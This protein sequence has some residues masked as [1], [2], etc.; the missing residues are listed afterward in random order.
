VRRTGAEGL[1]EK[2]H[3][4]VTVTYL[5]DNRQVSGVLHVTCMQSTPHASS[6]SNATGCILVLSVLCWLA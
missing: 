6:C 4:L 1:T 5:T 2:K 3:V